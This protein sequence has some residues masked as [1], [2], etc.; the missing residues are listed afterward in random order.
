[1]INLH[2]LVPKNFHSAAVLLPAEVELFSLRLRWEILK[3]SALATGGLDCGCNLERMH[4]RLQPLAA[5]AV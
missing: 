1:M 3:F 5:D 2:L 4:G